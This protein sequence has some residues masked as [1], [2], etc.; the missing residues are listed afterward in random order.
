[1]EPG[2]K[3][4]PGWPITIN[5]LDNYGRK[6]VAYLPEIRIMG[7]KNPV[8]Q[9]IDEINSETI[10]TLRINGN[11]FSPKVFHKGNYTVKISEPDKQIE[12]VLTSVFSIDGDKRDTLKIEFQVQNY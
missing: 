6:A 5:Q 2:A 3:Q 9:V 4:F 11:S 1:M 10:Y 8:I 7:M 12:K